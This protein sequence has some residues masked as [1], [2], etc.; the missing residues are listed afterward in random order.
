MQDGQG[1]GSVGPT[2]MVRLGGEKDK[3]LWAGCSQGNTR[4]GEG[5][6]SVCEVTVRAPA[7]EHRWAHMGSQSDPSLDAAL[8]LEVESAGSE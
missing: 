7:V 4:R 5:G 1:W 8:G 3:E 2:R 6:V